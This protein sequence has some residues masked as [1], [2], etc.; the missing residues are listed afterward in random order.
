MHDVKA[1]AKV[2]HHYDIPVLYNGAYTVGILPVDG[3]D[4]GVDFVVG[5]GHKSIGCPAPSGILAAPGKGQR[6]CSVQQ[7]LKAT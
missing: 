2:V 7:Q 5:S 4:L 3:K 6:K 1:I